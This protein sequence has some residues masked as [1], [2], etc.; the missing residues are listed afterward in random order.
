MYDVRSK[1]LP[2]RLEID[3]R[4]L[5]GRKSWHHVDVRARRRSLAGSDG[6]MHVVA[7]GGQRVQDSAQMA[8]SSAARAQA[9]A[10][11]EDA[12]EPF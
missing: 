4:L 12:H 2:E 9:I 8:M 1:L 6:E 11:M 3:G 5:T 7:L 10:Q